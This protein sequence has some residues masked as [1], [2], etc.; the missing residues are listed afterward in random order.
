MKGEKE[1]L[2]KELQILERAKLMLLHSYAACKSIEQKES[3]SFSEL[4]LFEALTSRFARLN[5]ITIRKMFRLIDRLDAEPEG[6]TRDS[7]LRAEKKGL[8]DDADQ[9]GKIREI[10][11]II[12][13]EYLLEDMSR[14]YHEVMTGIPILIEVIDRIK[15]Y[16]QRY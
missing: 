9:F 1:L 13:H 2:D 8:I 10:R 4:D 3:Y 5:D 16:C 15:N 12:A 11:N 7:I 6:T 14:L